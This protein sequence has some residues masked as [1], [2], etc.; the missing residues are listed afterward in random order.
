MPEETNEPVPIK[1]QDGKKLWM[2]EGYRI[3]AATYYEALELLPMI[4]SF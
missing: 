1:E 3:W 2:I 4:K